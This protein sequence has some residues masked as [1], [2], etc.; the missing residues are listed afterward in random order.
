[1]KYTV[2]LEKPV[3]RFLQSHSD[4]AKKLFDK[5]KEMEN[6]FDLSRFDIQKL[7]WSK[8][9]YRLRIWKYRFLF[10]WSIRL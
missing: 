6:D 9:N 3:I 8:N 2:I 1:M 7:Q 4:I 5:A 10:V